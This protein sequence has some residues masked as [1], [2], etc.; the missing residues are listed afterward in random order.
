[1]RVVSLSQLCRSSFYP[2]SVRCRDVSKK[3]LILRK[4]ERT[5]LDALQELEKLLLVH[6]G[7]LHEGTLIQSRARLGDC[8]R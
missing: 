5:N 3:G 2:G 1:M 6:I 4:L 8:T 7:L